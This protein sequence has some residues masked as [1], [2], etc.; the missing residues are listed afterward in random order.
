MQL[1]EDCILIA[2]LNAAMVMDMLTGKIRNRLILVGF[3]LGLLCKLQI[4]GASGGLAFASGVFL[5]FVWTFPLFAFGAVG[6]GDVKL[7]AVIGGFLGKAAMPQC[8]F[9][10]LIFGAV[11]AILKMSFQGSLC[12]RM[13]Y[14]SN[15]VGQSIRNR[16]F[17]PY[18]QPLQE[19]QAVIHMSVP[20]LLAVLACMIGGVV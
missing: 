2:I 17:A 16:R 4:H 12:R 11:A 9:L 10:T 18:G 5:P 7:L 15:Y 20:I 8:L 13:A 6:A 1:L 19:G 3:I 14:L